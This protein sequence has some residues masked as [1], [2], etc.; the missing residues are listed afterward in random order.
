VGRALARSGARNEG[1]EKIM[2]YETVEQIMHR[3][4]VL[5]GLLGEHYEEHLKDCKDERAKLLLDYMARHERN[6]KAVLEKYQTRAA[7]S[8]LKTWLQYVPE[9]LNGHLLENFKLEPEMTLD[10][11]VQESM[12]IDRALVDMYVQ[13]AGMTSAPEVQQF[14]EALLDMEEAKEIDYARSLLGEEE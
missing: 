2:P 11:I 3:V 10:E 8:V 13:F 9:E 6:M 7:E 14:F 1:G 12:Q 5:Y 4:E